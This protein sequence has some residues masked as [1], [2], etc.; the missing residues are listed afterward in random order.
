VT[1]RPRSWP[2]RTAFAAMLA[3]SALGVLAAFGGAGAGSAT[4]SQYE[5]QY[6]NKVLVC[7]RASA[8]DRPARYVTIR[9]REYEV[10][11]HLSHGDTLGPCVRS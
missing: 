9:V 7:H 3:V 1:E 6:N 11:F 5:Y 4:A 10:P 8:W 2:I